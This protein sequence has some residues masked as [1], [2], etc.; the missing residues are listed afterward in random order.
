MEFF[1]EKFLFHIKAGRK[2][3]EP[4]FVVANNFFTVTPDICGSST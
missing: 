1:K 2:N 4:Q 3:P